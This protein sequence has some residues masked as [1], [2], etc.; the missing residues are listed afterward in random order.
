MSVMI[1]TREQAADHL[2]IDDATPEA[3]DLDLKILAASGIVLDYIERDASYYEVTPDDDDYYYAS[4]PTADDT[5]DP[6]YSFPYQLQM[7]V[8]LLVGDMHRHRDTGNF[9]YKWQD[10]QL[11]Q[12]VRALLYPLKS[13]GLSDG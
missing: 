8:L 12:A 3:D 7:A 4:G 5:G 10:A 13:W 6:T 9:Q 2:R 11:P 1:V